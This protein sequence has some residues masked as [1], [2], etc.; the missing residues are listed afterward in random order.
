ME[1]KLNLFYPYNL[2]KCSQIFHFAFILF[3][4]LLLFYFFTFEQRTT[5]AMAIYNESQLIKRKYNESKKKMH[6]DL[7]IFLPFFYSIYFECFFSC[8]F[9]QYFVD[10]FLQFIS[11]F[12]FIFICLK[13]VSNILNSNIV[14][15]KSLSTNLCY[16]LDS[17]ESICLKCSSIFVVS[18]FS[19]LTFGIILCLVEKYLL[20]CNCFC[21]LLCVCMY[22]Q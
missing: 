20:L 11:S 16:S 21:F 13:E 6:F 14:T 15:L 9:C 22:H 8:W 7:Q 1:L 4:I 17:Y 5:L 19:F 2:Q 10:F 3:T 12:F 18:C